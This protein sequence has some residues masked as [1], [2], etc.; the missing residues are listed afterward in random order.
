MPENENDI[1]LRKKVRD[2]WGSTLS[3]V[4]LPGQ[5]IKPA[6][7]RQTM[8]APGAEPLPLPTVPL[9][10]PDEQAAARSAQIEI[11]DVIGEGGMG[12]IYRARQKSLDR[13][14]AL[15]R[16][17]PHL[18]M[19]QD[20]VDM[21]LG[22]AHATG[23]LDHPNIVPVYELGR[24]DKGQAFYSMKLVHGTPW[25]KLLHPETDE[26]RA[27]ADS[28]TIRDHLDILLK[29]SD[30]IG[31]A[32]S[33][34]V[35]HRDLKPENVM[36]G[37]FGEVLVMDWGL[38]ATAEPGLPATRRL[39]DVTKITAACGTPSYMPPEM[40]LGEGFRTCPASDVY[41][42]GAILFEILF[43]KPPHQGE[44]VW[45]VLWA[46]SENRIAKPDKAPPEVRSYYQALRGVLNKSLNIHP[47]RRQPDAR[48]FGEEVRAALSHFDSVAMATDAHERVGELVEDARGVTPARARKLYAG[49]AESVAGLKQ[50]LRSWPENPLAGTW[51]A[52]A[53]VEYARLA[54]TMSDFGLAE[55]QIAQVTDPD[56]ET[57]RLR[58]DIRSAH[59]QALARERSARLMRWGLGA[60]ALVVFAVTAAAFFWVRSEQKKAEH[61][62]D[63]AEEALAARKALAK[64]AAPEFLAKSR[65]L[66]ETGKFKE[67][68]AAI[69]M[70]INL[71]DTMG[72]FHIQRGYLL[73]DSLRFEESIEAFEAAAER[74]APKEA[75]ETNVRL[76]EKIMTLSREV[77]RNTGIGIESRPREIMLPLARALEAQGRYAQASRAY[78]GQ[79]M[80][81]AAILKRWRTHLLGAGPPSL[82]K[83]RDPGQRL[84]LDESLGI[85]L[86]LSGVQDV[87]SIEFLR[88]MPL[89]KL[90]LQGCSR[91]KS[92]DSLQ[93][94][95]LKELDL[96]RC[97][98][99]ADLTPLKGMPLEKL[100]L[101]IFRDAVNKVL[102][103]LE[104]LRGMK[105][106]RL[107]IENCK[108]VESLA[109]LKGMPL[110]YLNIRDC[111]NIR[112]LSPLK[113][114]RIKELH[115]AGSGVGK[116]RQAPAPRKKPP[117]QPQ[118]K[119]GEG[120]KDVF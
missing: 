4:E 63:R 7:A 30:A 54:L 77:K 42:L 26:Q 104:P 1:D 35:I 57:K 8:A 6:A 110:E 66:T 40:A 69:E 113:G 120:D 100:N 19:R 83:E 95:Q 5:S 103:S 65:K 41:L 28:M 94:M 34:G 29:V 24:D 49:F 71:D 79:T 9:S 105:L 31:F 92:L 70:A 14:V 98:R 51:L 16:I 111:K 10:I 13:E 62:R 61:Q 15:K 47:A 23:A 43:G 64:K 48:A 73:Q 107:N 96:A 59:K 91:L 3:G 118:R 80:P 39:P 88:G 58:R 37:E 109:P 75:V 108:A 76:S 18:E 81:N 89:K 52:E 46:A 90:Y 36:V 44:T 12:T 38:A 50:A 11:L 33:R 102:R 86:N 119:E 67:A 56:D 84:R 55:A 114:M 17:K 85:H 72:D 22:E 101:F 99:I 115:I 117:S 20:V 93:G 53:H 68:L 21:F 2:V 106:K 78:A 60:A 74:G 112:D 25:N 116:A 97:H 87:E 45:A 27:R 32:H 82:K